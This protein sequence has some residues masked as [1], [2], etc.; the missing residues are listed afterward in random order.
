MTSPLSRRYTTIWSIQ[1][2]GVLRLREVKDLP[3][4]TQLESDKDGIPNKVSLT[5][6]PSP[7][8]IFS[9]LSDPSPVGTNDQVEMS[10]TSGKKSLCLLGLLTPH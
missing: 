7:L 6:K 1:Q 8:G 3:R 10:H 9:L 5:I 4:V 2:M